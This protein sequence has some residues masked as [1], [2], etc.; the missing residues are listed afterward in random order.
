MNKKFQGFLATLIN[1]KPIMAGLRCFTF[2]KV[3]NEAVKI[4][5]YQ[6][7]SK[8]SRYIAVLPKS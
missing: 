8:I 4:V 7:I 3:N 1:E 6:N 5:K 2:S